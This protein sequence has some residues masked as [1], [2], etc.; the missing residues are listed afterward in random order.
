MRITLKL[1]TTWHSHIK[2]SH[3][4]L[5]RR[6]L[7]LKQRR[8]AKA[9]RGSIQATIARKAQAEE[10][11]R[12]RERQLG[13]AAQKPTTPVAACCVALHLP[14]ALNLNRKKRDAP[15][16]P[17]KN[18]VA[19]PAKAPSRL[20]GRET[21]EEEGWCMVCGRLRPL[22]PLPCR[23][24]LSVS[25]LL[26][27]YATHAVGWLSPLCSFAANYCFGLKAGSLRGQSM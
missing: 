23:S 26:Q 10:R 27:M 17:T 8:K 25:T 13:V 24:F 11:R 15:R 6:A 7:S 18:K 2:T 21:G 20:Q 5:S 1:T 14:E 9:L 16:Q 4:F 12:E 3:T 22:V 19:S